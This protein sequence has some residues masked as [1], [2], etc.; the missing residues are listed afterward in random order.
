MTKSKI[1]TLI[2][3]ESF[4]HVH[5]GCRAQIPQKYFTYLLHIT[6]ICIQ[7]YMHEEIQ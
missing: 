7:L 4:E 2:S 1:Q 5:S 3:S 6:C